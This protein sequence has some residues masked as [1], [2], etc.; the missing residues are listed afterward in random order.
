L[1][2]I[3]G[4]VVDSAVDSSVVGLGRPKC[5]GDNGGEDANGTSGGDEGNASRASIL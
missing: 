5:V 3:R 4:F 1:S 2:C